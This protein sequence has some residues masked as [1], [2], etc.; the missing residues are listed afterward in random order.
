MKKMLSRIV[1]PVRVSMHCHSVGPAHENAG[2]ATTKHYWFE[3]TSP[4]CAKGFHQL[5]SATLG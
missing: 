2:A 5:G 1:Q 4:A 3:E